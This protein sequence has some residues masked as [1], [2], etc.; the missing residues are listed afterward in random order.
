MYDLIKQIGKEDVEYIDEDL[1]FELCKR[2]GIHAIVTGSFTQLGDIFA[3]DVKVLDVTTKKLLK[4]VSSRGEG[5]ESILKSQIDELSK[6]ISKGID[7]RVSRIDAD[8]RL[9]AEVTTTSMDAYYYYLRG[10][11]EQQKMYYDEAQRFYEQA[12]LLDSTFALAYLGL[13][14]A[15]FNLG[16]YKK[17]N[18]ALE[19]A[20]SYS[21]KVTEK[22]RFYIETTVAWLIEQNPDKRFRIL[23]ELVKKYP[24]EKRAHNLFA[25]YYTRRNLYEKALEKYTKVL[26]LD[27]FYRP[28][29]NEIGY[30]Y[31][32]M[33]D[34]E[35]ALESFE[36]YASVYPDD[37]GPIDSIGETYFYM[38]KPDEALVKFEEVVQLNAYFNIKP[39]QLYGKTL[40]KILKDQFCQ[41][42]GARCKN[43]MA[44][45]RAATSPSIPHLAS[46]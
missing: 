28:A 27:P 7:I 35:K 3:T 37:A 6:E 16:N 1:G 14:S 25:R 22:E 36:R 26:E 8:Q 30:L 21:H 17:Q 23:N 39:R 10:R 29:L 32:V 20:R 13:T 19:K 18:E 11:E 4:S 43:S 38:G 33:M 12:V 46:D 34:Y 44:Q 24:G 42:Q 40:Y 31:L 45:L 2:D 15:Y 9:I 5:V 41:D